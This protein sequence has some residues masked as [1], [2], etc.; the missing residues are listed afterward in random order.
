MPIQIKEILVKATVS[1][2][3]TSDTG[4]ESSGS[5]EEQIAQIKSEI[6]EECLT[7][8]FFQLNKNKER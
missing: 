8:I 5:C 6:I 2:S 7:S 4:G 3:T 1:S